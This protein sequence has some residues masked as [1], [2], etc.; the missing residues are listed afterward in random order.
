MVC[1]LNLYSAHETKTILWCHIGN[2]YTI[3]SPYPYTYPWILVEHL[4]YSIVRV[5]KCNSLYT[6]K[7]SI[8]INWQT[9]LIYHLHYKAYPK[10]IF[11]QY[12]IICLIELRASLRRGHLLFCIKVNI[13][14]SIFLCGILVSQTFKTW[15]L[16]DPPSIF[17]YTSGLLSAH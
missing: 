2:F 11:Y 15:Y 7:T 1:I 4:D 6:A 13:T 10:S 9:C 8:T 14:Q 12:F 16:N 5:S 17:T 3:Q